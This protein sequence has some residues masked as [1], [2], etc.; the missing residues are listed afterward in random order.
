[1]GEKLIQEEHW[2]PAIL[3]APS[4]R[5]SET[6]FRRYQRMGEIS[7][8]EVIDFHYS[9]RELTADPEEEAQQV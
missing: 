6:D 2:D 8:D 9:L 7:P 5:S 1:V 4:K 3:R